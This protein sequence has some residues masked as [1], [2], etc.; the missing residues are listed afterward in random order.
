MFY[1]GDLAEYRLEILAG[2][3]TLHRATAIAKPFRAALL[4][5]M[6]QS[7]SQTTNLESVQRK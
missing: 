7:I 1:I 6:S 5:I 4:R 2:T 3:G